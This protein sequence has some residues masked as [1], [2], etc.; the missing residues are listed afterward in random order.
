MAAVWWR[1]TIESEGE[2]AEVLAAT[3]EG[4][5]TEFALLEQLETDVDLSGEVLVV[6]AVYR[7]PGDPFYRRRRLRV[8]ARV[9]WT[10]ED[11]T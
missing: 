9:V 7:V 1:V 3:P 2:T 8:Q 5:A 6:E 4:A 11:A 10:A